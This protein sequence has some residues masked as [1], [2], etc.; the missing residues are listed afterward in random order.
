MEKLK[1]F[2]NRDWTGSEKVLLVLCCVLFG[3]VWAFLSASAM[4]GT[5]YWKTGVTKNEW[6][7]ED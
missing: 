2:W 4:K 3:A 6:E 1:E 7:M 5:D